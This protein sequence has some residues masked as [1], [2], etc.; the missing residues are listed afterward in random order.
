V[1]RAL[2]AVP[3]IVLLAF[4]AIEV[5]AHA[6]TRARVPEMQDWRAAAS[7]VRAH[8]QPR[9]LIAAAP[10]WADPLLRQVLGDRIDLAMAGRSDAGAYERLW[11]VSIRGA[12]AREAPPGNA[13]L[14][15]RFGRV[16]VQRWALGPSDVLYDLV[17]HVHEAQVSVTEHGQPRPCRLRRHPAPR[18]GGLGVGALPPVERFA[19]DA[20]R[21]G[22]W[23]A[24]VVLED[25]ELRPR[26]CVLQPPAGSE[27][28]R[29]ALADVP[30]GD[31][32]VLYGGLYYEHER[33]REG[34]PVLARVLVDGRELGHMLHRDGDGWKRL[35]IQTA[36]GRGEVAIE[37]SAP[38]P[39]RRSFCWSASVR[40]RP[41]PLRPSRPR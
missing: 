40:A 1:K 4:A 19:C 21:A 18:G 36:G 37:I 16:S 28:V 12:R 5:S 35:V 39:D 23:V 38:N 25:L 14:E 11:V 30:L 9:D 34:G 41:D 2:S 10:D 3:F 31:R 20:G 33:M 8:M 29:V 6:I 22:S 27:P 7:F 13:A 24:P 17:E 26:Y 15:Q 32:L